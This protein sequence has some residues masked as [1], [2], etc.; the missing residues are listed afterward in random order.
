MPQRR[1]ALIER[2]ETLTEQVAAKLRTALTG[3]LF[4]PGEK[5]TIRAV[6]KA[7][8]VS[9]TPAREALAALAAEGVLESTAGRSLIVP[10]LNQERLNELT[11]VRVSLECLAAEVALERM[12]AEEV[13]SVI[14]A[15]ERLKRATDAADFKAAILANRQ[16]HF[17]IYEAARMPT[18]LRM[19]EALWLRT[20][21][22]VNLIYPAFGLA[23]K[24]IENHDRAARAIEERDAGAL[25]AA[26][27]YDIRYSAQ[28]IADAL[29]KRRPAAVA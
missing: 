29:P 5:I 28:H 14:A 6:A 8:G 17:A 2:S 16:F 15:N 26:I 21:A 20:G 9:P 11:R 23:R 24:G 7:L 18:L 1:L 25:R 27:E 19:I 4:A 12:T 13:R 22:Y 10:P 3:G